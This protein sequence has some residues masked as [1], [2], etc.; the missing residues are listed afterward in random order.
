MQ[1]HRQ[2]LLLFIQFYYLPGCFSLIC[3][4]CNGWDGQY[5]LRYATA[6]TCDNRNNQCQTSQF[7]VKIIDSMS[8]GTNYGTFKSDCY[9]QTQ[10]QIDPQNLTTITNRK[11]YP[12][13]DGSAPVKRYW[14]CFCNDHDYCNSSKSLPHFL[15]IIFPILLLVYREF[16]K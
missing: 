3:Q 8:P 1:I 2:H 11:C 15:S 5:P 12:Y 13:Q 14:Y 16:S 6:S 10:L 4:Q 7:C 9:F